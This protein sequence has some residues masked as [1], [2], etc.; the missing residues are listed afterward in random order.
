MKVKIFAT[1]RQYVN[2]KE[3][4]VN[5]KAGDTVRDVLEKLVANNSELGEH[6]F[7][8]EGNLQRSIRVLVKGRNIEFK[9]GLNT[10][11]KKDDYLALFPPVG[12]G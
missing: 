10:V 8:K 5:A 3:V 1:L 12:G 2:F 7:D 11:L 9:D 4:E 6:I